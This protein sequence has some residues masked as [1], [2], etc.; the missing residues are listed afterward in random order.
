[1]LD[2][3]RILLKWRRPLVGFALLAAVVAAA[4]AFLVTPRYYSEASILPPNDEPSFGG[5]SALLEQYQI[6]IP[7]GVKSPFLPTLYASIVSS[8]KMGRLILDEY[9]LRTVFKTDND[10]DALG[11]LRGRTSLKY[12]DDGCS[13]SATKIRIRSAPRMWSMPTSSIWIRSSKR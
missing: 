12:T 1:M 13:W 11:I 8:R 6:P 3:F 9:S 10:D 4:Y 2:L 7:G 5:L